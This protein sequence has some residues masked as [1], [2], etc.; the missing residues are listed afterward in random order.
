LDG[1]RPGARGA[2]AR[3]GGRILDGLRRVA[4][5]G[6]LARAALGIALGLGWGARGE[7]LVAALLRDI[8]RTLA[9]TRRRVDDL[10]NV[11]AVDALAVAQRLFRWTGA[12]P[13]VLVAVAGTAVLVGSTFAV[14]GLALRT[15]ATAPAST[16]ATMARL[17]IG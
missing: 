8:C 5:V 7:A 3:A 10:P 15:G 14:K 9:L 6:A 16:I 12:Y 4:G 2:R 1:L 11:G 13:A 17:M